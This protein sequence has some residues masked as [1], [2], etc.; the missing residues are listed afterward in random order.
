MR[1]VSRPGGSPSRRAPER[2]ATRSGALVAAI[3]LLLPILSACGGRAQPAPG[4]GYVRGGLPELRGERVMVFPAQV[5]SGV[6]D[7]VDL[8]IAYALGRSSAIVEWVFP[9]EIQAAMDRSPGFRIPLRELPVSAFLVAEI[10]RIGD[11]LYGDLYRL[12]ILTNAA[13]ALIPIEA[14][15]RPEGSEQVAE[16]TAALVDARSGRVAWYA[17]VEGSRGAPGSLPVTATAADALA[18]AISP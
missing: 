17:V 2:D 15:A 3:L 8:E 16:V 4:P 10:E 18:R 12:A 7:D 14:E 5:R 11:P 1:R 9:D 6:H 13:F